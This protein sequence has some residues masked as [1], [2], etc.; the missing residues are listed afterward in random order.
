MK[1]VWISYCT[2]FEAGW[3][4]RPDGF[5]MS[6]DREALEEYIKTKGNGGSH[7]YFWRCDEPKEVLCDDDTL[8]I[9][10][11]KINEDGVAHFDNSD[12]KELKLFKEI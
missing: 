4:Q 11:E 7:D 12:K 10:K 8:K 1:K 9:V 3:G 6:E 5:V 2:E